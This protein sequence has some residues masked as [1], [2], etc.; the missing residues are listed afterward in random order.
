MAVL[1]QMAVGITALGELE[2]IGYTTVLSEEL[3]LSP[4]VSKKPSR[5]YSQSLAA[6]DAVVKKPDK[7]C[8]E[9]ADFGELLIRYPGKLAVETLRTC[10][11]YSRIV[12]WYRQFTE[13]LSKADVI[14]KM[15][16]RLLDEVVQFSDAV[17]KLALKQCIEQIRTVDYLV[18]V[19][20]RSLVD[21]ITLASVLVRKRKLVSRRTL[22]PARFEDIIR[23]LPSEREEPAIHE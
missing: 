6:T 17:V 1:S 18:K 2:F 22:S 23:E 21:N 7:L 10:D 8:L 5:M 19:P 4:L 16:A 15:P 13:R 11:V 12:S 14:R 9:L 3:A 20:L